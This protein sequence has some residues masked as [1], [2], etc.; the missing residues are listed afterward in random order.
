MECDQVQRVLEKPS[1]SCLLT[2]NN[3]PISL[4]QKSLC[5]SSPRLYCIDFAKAYVMQENV[6]LRIFMRKG[7]ICIQSN[8]RLHEK[9]LQRKA[10]WGKYVGTYPGIRLP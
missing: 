1:S 8:G 7:M 10:E 3:Q 2:S 6:S 9:P 4:V 5:D